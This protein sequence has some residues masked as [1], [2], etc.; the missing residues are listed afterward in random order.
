MKAALSF[1]VGTLVLGAAAGWV[2]LPARQDGKVE[3]RETLQTPATAPAPAPAPPTRE[4][5]LPTTAGLMEESKAWM[6]SITEKGFNPYAEEMEKWTDEEIRSA[7][8]ESLRNRDFLM[9][10]KSARSIASGLLKEWMKRDCAAASEFFLTI[11]APIRNGAMTYSFSVA[12]PAEHAAEGLAFVKANPQVFEGASPWSILSKNIEARAAGGA[13]SVVGLLG[14]LR[15]A[16]LDLAFEN[17]VKLPEGFDFGTLM[18]SPEMEELTRKNQAK[19]FVRAWCTQDREACFDWMVEKGNL[20]DLPNLI[21]F[22]P[23]HAEGLRWVG[24]KYET[25]DPSARD[26]IARGIR[27]GNTE[28]VQKMAEGMADVEVAGGLRA[29]GGEWVFAGAVPAAMQVLEGI[30]DPARRL[31][32]LEEVE[33]AKMRSVRP[34]SRG[35]AQ[36]FRKYLQEWN[37]TPEQIEAIVTKFQRPK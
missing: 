27:I 14:E 28:V 19:F 29:I 15:E 30:P 17:P 7:L 25:M 3:A 34:M 11:P 26:K 22:S 18:K 23:D 16:K 36:I 8:Q 9:D 21:A 24:S 33:Q 2:V 4:R 1:F 10:S 5:P 31:Q 32:V 13:A 6:K 20:Q 37:A 35:D 12:W